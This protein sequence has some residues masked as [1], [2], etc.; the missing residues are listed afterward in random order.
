MR[1]KLFPPEVEAKALRDKAKVFFDKPENAGPGKMPGYRVVLVTDFPTQD[2]M[3]ADTVYM[4]EAPNINPEKIVCHYQT[5][6]MQVHK[7]IETLQEYKE[8]LTIKDHA[9]QKRI[10]NKLIF[11]KQLPLR[12]SVIKTE[13]GA[14]YILGKS[15]ADREKSL[16][17]Q[18]SKE[19]YAGYGADAAAGYAMDE[20][21]KICIDRTTYIKSNTS[22]DTTIAQEVGQVKDTA[23]LTSQSKKPLG[24][25]SSPTDTKYHE[26]Q[27]LGEPLDSFM[28]KKNATGMQQKGILTEDQRFRIAIRVAIEVAKL[29]AMN[30][31]HR[32]LKP[33]N[34]LIDD[35]T[36]KITIVD[37]GFS[38][39]NI[40][41][42]ASSTG[43]PP[44]MPP[45]VT[46]ASMN[47]LQ[48]DI[49]ALIK[50]IH[51]PQTGGSVKLDKPIAQKTLQTLN[52]TSILDAQD[53]TLNANIDI[54]YD[55]QG[56][57][58]TT[59]NYASVEDMAIA[60]IAARHSIPISLPDQH[61]KIAFLKRYDDVISQKIDE[62]VTLKPDDVTNII[63]VTAIE[64]AKN[65][66]QNK[67]IES[68]KTAIQ[69]V[70]LA[71]EAEEV[72]ALLLTAIAENKFAFVQVAASIPIQFDWNACVEQLP[73][74]GENYPDIAALIL[75]KKFESNFS[76]EPNLES[77]LSRT[78]D[79]A[80]LINQ[81]GQLNDISRTA[82][83]LLVEAQKKIDL[84]WCLT[85]LISDIAKTSKSL[86]TTV[87]KA[88]E[89][90]FALSLNKNLEKFEALKKFIEIHK[91]KF[92]AV[93]NKK[94]Q[95][96][97]SN[98][99]TTL[100]PAIQKI[101]SDFPKASGTIQE[102][103][104]IITQCKHFIEKS[105][106]TTQEDKDK[107]STAYRE[108]YITIYQVEMQKA[109]LK[110]ADAE[111]NIG[112]ILE[113]VN[114]TALEEEEKKSLTDF[115]KAKKSLIPLYNLIDT[116]NGNAIDLSVQ[117]EGKPKLVSN[118][119]NLKE[120]LIAIKNSLNNGF[121]NA[122]RNEL[123][124]TL[125]G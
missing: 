104:T 89:P 108:S 83:T 115:A 82:L 106:N 86:S 68:F 38:K 25:S 59:K 53:I 125:E 19:A 10:L 1:E 8:G 114:K 117:Y 71:H 33:A 11:N 4:K 46:I 107:I 35:K 39:K 90:Q 92:S 36:H 20:S 95:K 102:K 15:L 87:E 7:Q 123:E 18:R 99:E 65:A 43:T 31:A 93:D 97:I 49:H 74:V 77:A 118:I 47:Y 73:K 119:S 84:Q 120:K 55:L 122:G 12:H 78:D 34:I 30:I 113:K 116:L 98:T 3:E 14:L 23:T 32:D 45:E 13:K 6:T 16:D 61:K 96:H 28:L 21:G 85:K 121:I 94:I 2:K 101:L 52:Q 27:E 67:N 91:N 124:K 79:A 50:T 66:L 56:N 9:A 105:E 69:A 54:L 103:I 22:V 80:K 75:Q 17:N 70:H 76:T 81:T 60:M 41:H 24:E 37:F 40:K 5:K 48:M 109:L 57:Q 29:H 58:L 62:K 72:K 110:P 88:G 64:E 42:G 100:A 26:F 111:K 63:A 51:F 112:D 44:Y